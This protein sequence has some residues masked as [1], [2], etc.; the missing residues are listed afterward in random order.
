LRR[1]IEVP[2]LLERLK[3]GIGPVKTVGEYA[4][5]LENLYASLVG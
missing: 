4:G 5:E 1:L 3:D 2:G